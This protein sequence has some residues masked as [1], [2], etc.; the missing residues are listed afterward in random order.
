MSDYLATPETWDAGS[1]ASG[2]CRWLEGLRLF[3][4]ILANRSVAEVRIKGG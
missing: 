3:R 2:D 4:L 1:S